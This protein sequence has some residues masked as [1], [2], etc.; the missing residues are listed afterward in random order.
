M[1][2][3]VL[4]C[5]R[6]WRVL[7]PSGV[8]AACLVLFALRN[9]A[10]ALP[11]Q[12]GAENATMETSGVPKPALVAG[13]PRGWYPLA[14]SPAS[15]HFLL[16]MSNVYWDCQRQDRLGF[17]EGDWES[18]K[19]AAFS[20]DGKWLALGG[21]DWGVKAEVDYLVLFDARTRKPVRRLG[22]KEDPNGIGNTVY[23]VAFSPDSAELA[24][25]GL[26][27]TVRLWDV[28]SG[29][30]LRVLRGHKNT[31]IDLT[32]SPDGKAVLSAGHDNTIR[33]WDR[34]TGRLIRTLSSPDTTSFDALAISPE[35]GLIAAAGST[36]D[37]GG[38][39]VLWDA[40]SGIQLGALRVNRGHLT[41]VAFLREA[42]W[43]VS[44]GWGSQVI[45]W[46]T[47]KRKPV[48][49][50]PHG[51]PV[52]EM[53]VSPDGQWLAT[54]ENSSDNVKIWDCFPKEQKPR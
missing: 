12:R 42:R 41:G 35:G 48:C 43:L 18:L 34:A 14:F 1:L 30:E 33:V 7:V 11:P 2:R 47:V 22:G 25:G 10:P 23:R 28:P 5:Q 54:L 9:S 8:M 50:L 49:T 13:S 16:L 45:L 31:V 4:G 32:Y 20:R 39:V 51:S 19:C 40:A 3:K 44:A 6:W 26:D 36:F 21:F 17:V 53:A 27:E 52:H 15:S 46:D 24:S 38:A 29:K 37:H